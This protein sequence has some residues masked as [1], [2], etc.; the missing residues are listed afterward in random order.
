MLEKSGIPI[1]FLQV[2]DKAPIN[3]AAQQA[4]IACPN[5]DVILLT[6]EDCPLPP[7]VK[8]FRIGDYGNGFNVFRQAYKHTSANPEGYELI[9]FARWFFVREFVQRHKISRFC[10]FDSDIMLF[11]PV[12]HFAAEFDGHMAGNWAWAN[13]F[14]DISALDV[15]CD[16]YL[17][18]FRDPPLL[19]QLAEKYRQHGQPHVSDMY[20]LFELAESDKRFLDQKD[21]PAKG[22]DCNI[23]LSEDGIFEMN[24]DIKYLTF[25]PN[26][27]PVAKRCQDGA[28]VPFHFL[29]FQGLAKRLMTQVAWK[30]PSN[31]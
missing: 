24:G 9:C 1:I 16:Y 8:Q 6:D 7:S 11:S 13:Y 10:I 12:E 25:A 27:R 3:I 4:V 20:L 23:Q 26:S 5:S 15:M 2:G 18:V 14:S 21:F 19:A 29:H 17:S 22:Y 28:A 30:Q 31:G